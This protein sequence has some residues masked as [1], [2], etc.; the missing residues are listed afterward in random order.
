MKAVSFHQDIVPYFYTEELA[1]QLNQNQV[2]IG[3]NLLKQK[4]DHGIKT[5]SNSCVGL[6]MSGPFIPSDLITTNIQPF[7]RPS[8]TLI[9]ANSHKSTSD[10]TT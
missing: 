7:S 2:S 5:K 10:T 6:S 9:L 8:I 1:N 3:I 4:M